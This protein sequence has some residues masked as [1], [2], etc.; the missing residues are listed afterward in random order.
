MKEFAAYYPSVYSYDDA[1][2]NFH[3]WFP[4]YN[5]DYWKEY[6]DIRTGIGTGQHRTSGNQQTS[7]AS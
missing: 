4:K 7:W 2:P 3:P 1:A 5:Q 6:Q